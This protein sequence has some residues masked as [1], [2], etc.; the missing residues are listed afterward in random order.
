MEA[1][2]SI[3]ISLVDVDAYELAKEY[4]KEI[5]REGL[6]N[7]YFRYHIGEIEYH[8][9]NYEDA[10]M[11][12]ERVLEGN[13]NYVKANLLMAR[14]AWNLKEYNVFG[15]YLNRC[16][17]IDPDMQEAKGLQKEWNEKGKGEE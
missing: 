3:V 14:C 6:F 17:Q 7:E 10:K 9:K 16:L 1:R 15:K 11:M 12:M 2:D 8:Q 5:N 13:P 4:A